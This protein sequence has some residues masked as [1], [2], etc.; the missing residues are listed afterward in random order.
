MYKILISALA[1]VVLNGCSP[2]G[3]L[4]PLE[5]TKIHYIEEDDSQIYVCTNRPIDENHEKNG[6]VSIY[7]LSYK[8]E[9]KW[10]N[11]ISSGD[12]YYALNDVQ[13][14]LKKVLSDGTNCYYLLSQSNWRL[15]HSKAASKENV[16]RMKSL[17][18][19]NIKKI[20]VSLYNNRNL[21]QNLS[22]DGTD[23]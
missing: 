16:E 13:S 11:I 6:P 22:F 21:I 20:S 15:S 2:D 12:G 19:E 10:Y 3:K 5:I 17:K 9:D 23:L 1:I 7:Q 4:Q 14:T 18:K 8:V